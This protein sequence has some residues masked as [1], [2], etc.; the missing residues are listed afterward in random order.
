MV[1]HYFLNALVFYDA[2]AAPKTKSFPPK[3]TKFRE[4]TTTRTLT[5][6]LTLHVTRKTTPT[7]LIRDDLNEDIFERETE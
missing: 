5:R 6:T 4:M 7:P 1:Q 3:N 2:S